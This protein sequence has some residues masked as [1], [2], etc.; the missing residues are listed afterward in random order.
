MESTL[1]LVIQTCG[2]GIAVGIVTLA[3]LM[4][5]E[6]K[7]MSQTTGEPEARL[8]QMASKVG[9]FLPKAAYLMGI[10]E[11]AGIDKL[12]QIKIRTDKAG[13]EDFLHANAID[14]AGFEEAQRVLLLPDAAWWDP[15]KA[16]SLPT[17]Q[18]NRSPG[19]TLNI[20]YATTQNGDVE[21]YIMWFTS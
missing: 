10:S 1:K 15:S 11:E 18:I 17:V 6:E 16:P 9:L 4:N 2:C 13:L 3:I 21:L 12:V 8:A 14:R 5:M 7:T 20:G 19:A